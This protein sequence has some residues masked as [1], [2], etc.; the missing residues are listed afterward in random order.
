M[1]NDAELRRSL[2]HIEVARPGSKK[3]GRGTG[4]P[5]GPDRV[6]TALHVVAGSVSKVEVCFPDL[7]G[8]RRYLAKVI[9][10]ADAG[11]HPEVGDGI[12][13]AALLQLEDSPS[14]LTSALLGSRVCGEHEQWWGRGFPRAALRPRLATREGATYESWPYTG[15]VAGA[16]LQRADGTWSDLALHVDGEPDERDGWKGASG[17]PVIIGRELHGIVRSVK[18]E[19]KERLSA[20]SVRALLVA[21]GFTWALG[22]HAAVDEWRRHRASQVEALVGRFSRETEIVEQISLLTKLSDEPGALADGLMHLPVERFCGVCNVVHA[23]LAKTG[24]REA[25]RT[26]FEVLQE[27]APL[28][29]DSGLVEL[30]LRSGDGAVVELRAKSPTLAA[31]VAAAADKQPL[32]ARMPTAANDMVKAA[33]Q[34]DPDGEETG[35]GGASV[36]VD[37]IR[38]QLLARNVN[39]QYWLGL[40]SNELNQKLREYLED[41]ADPMS[42][43]E[44]FRYFY[45][46]APNEVGRQVARELNSRFPLIRTFELQ[47]TDP[48]GEELKLTRALVDILLRGGYSLGYAQ[49]NPTG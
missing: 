44:P 1:A 47:G 31:L 2:A 5:V 41:Q 32:R 13:D 21:P 16:P 35:K 29:V 22:R 4:L 33:S 20:V 48:H 27:V 34:L 25:A 11:R 18:A 23:R 28:V 43:P 19:W 15:K 6:L 9:W 40:D 17:A 8:D 7:S 49:P 45:A 46:Y 38:E 36:I 3:V 24:R 10:P 12:L 37:R 14:G 42:T 39:E 30:V 26:V